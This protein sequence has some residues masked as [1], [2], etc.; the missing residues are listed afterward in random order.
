MSADDNQQALSALRAAIETQEQVKALHARAREFNARSL[1]VRVSDET[2]D[3]WAQL[4]LVRAERAAVDAEAKAE[5]AADA[6]PSEPAPSEP[7]STEPASTEPASAEP[8]SAE[9]A[10]AEPASAEPASA[11]PAFAEPASAELA[12]SEPESSEHALLCAYARIVAASDFALTTTSM[13]A[14]AGDVLVRAA[15][16]GCVVLVR[17]CLCADARAIRRSAFSRALVGAVRGRHAA[18]VQLLLADGRADPTARGGECARIERLM[19]SASAPSIAISALLLRDGRI[20]QPR[21]AL[22]AF[23]IID[24]CT[25]NCTLLANVKIGHFALH[26][27]EGYFISGIS[28]QGPDDFVRRFGDNALECRF[29][30]CGWTRTG[31]G[32]AHDL[33]LSREDAFFALAGQFWGEHQDAMR[34]QMRMAHV[35]DGSFAFDGS[36]QDMR[37]RS[38]N[39]MRADYMRLEI[40]ASGGIPRDELPRVVRVVYTLTD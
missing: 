17:V 6:A 32:S 29:E 2:V 8:A 5:A 36:R 24:N 15:T 37:Q 40:R 28:V 12:L 11:E 33:V 1:T 4:A 21:I 26:L 22:Q 35:P 23:D 27:Q 14:L 7:A 25:N 38:L 18:I 13:C 30:L 10:S 31:W 9:P 16:Q 3:H 20:R 34:I 19:Q 39:S